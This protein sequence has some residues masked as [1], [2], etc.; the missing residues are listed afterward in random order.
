MIALYCETT[1][2]RNR[3]EGS[4]SASR[5]RPAESRDGFEQLLGT[6][7]VGIA[8]LRQCSD[9]D[10]A[11]LR[12][13]VANGLAGPSCVVVTPLS[14][15]RLQR[16]RRIESTR[17]HV[18]WAEEAGDRLG[19]VLAQINPWHHDPLLLLGRRLVRDHSLHEC[20][21]NAIEH[22]C[23]LSPVE[24]SGPPT[25]SVEDLARWHAR[26]PPDTFRRYWRAQM[27]LRCPPKKLLSWALLLWAVRQRTRAKWAAIADEAGV[28]RRTIERHAAN[29]A[30]CPLTAASHDPEMVQRRFQEWVAEVS[31]TD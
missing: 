9:A 17:F 22:I 26:V 23:R 24:D 5:L 31:V 14:L 28:R 6:A 29:L 27:P 15:K 13:T 16:L 12:E 1:D 3:I 10:I 30:G 8:G 11:W 18:V 7:S 25:A 20:L 4:L 19:R 21:V 2:M